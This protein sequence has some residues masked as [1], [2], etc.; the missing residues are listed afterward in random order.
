MDKDDEEVISKFFY[1]NTGL[2]QKDVE[3]FM[4]ELK[5]G[6]VGDEAEPAD[7]ELEEEFEE[8]E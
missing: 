1:I 5:A 2:S 7:E 6:L 4:E 3:E 8:E